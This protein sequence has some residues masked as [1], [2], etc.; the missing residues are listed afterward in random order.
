MPE[1]E[2]WARLN[3]QL[4]ADYAATWAANLVI[5]ALGERTVVEALAAGIG[6][7]TIWREICAVLELPDNER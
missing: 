6:C 1:A 5:S 4:G 3:H 2:L 7:K